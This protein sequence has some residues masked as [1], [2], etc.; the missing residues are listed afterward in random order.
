MVAQGL[1][2]PRLPRGHR[3]AGGCRTHYHIPAGRGG[4]P[5]GSGRSPYGCQTTL[6]ADEKKSEISAE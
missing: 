3:C 6:K 1:A 4:A 5:T 2:D